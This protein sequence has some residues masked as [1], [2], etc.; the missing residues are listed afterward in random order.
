MVE[1][2]ENKT[3]KAKEYFSN[4]AIGGREHWA[5]III[6]YDES[7]FSANDG[8]QKAW[9]RKGASFLQPK[10]RGQGIMVFE[11]FVSVWSFKFI[12]TIQTIEN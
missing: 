6:T 11:F 10:G 1:F 8:I 7:T 4:C 3:I 12:F 9:T 5:V 2:N